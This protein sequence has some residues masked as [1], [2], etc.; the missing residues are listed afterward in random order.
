MEVEDERR[1]DVVVGGV[2]SGDVQ[3]EGPLDVAEVGIGHCK[4]AVMTL[5]GGRLKGGPQVA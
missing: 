5:Y 4:S 3:A 1:G 2:T